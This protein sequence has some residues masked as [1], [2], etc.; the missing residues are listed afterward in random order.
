MA[1]W[2]ACFGPVEVQYVMA[3]WCMAEEHF[4]LQKLRSKEKQEGAGAPI[5]SLRLR[6]ALMESVPFSD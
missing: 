2:P 3:V 1:A 6:T 4:P 5:S